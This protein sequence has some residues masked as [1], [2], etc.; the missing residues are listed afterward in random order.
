VTTGEGAGGSGSCKTYSFIRDSASAGT[1]RLPP[2]MRCLLLEC[3]SAPVASS[4]GARKAAAASLGVGRLRRSSSVESRKRRKKKID[5]CRTR[6]R[7]G[8]CDHKGRTSIGVVR[9]REG[10]LTKLLISTVASVDLEGKNWLGEVFNYSRDDGL[11]RLHNFASWN[12][13]NFCNL[14]YYYYLNT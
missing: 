13:G 12:I 9:E 6:T 14:F 1:C 10:N 3:R 11:I 7:G 8:R 5:G 2:P 4:N